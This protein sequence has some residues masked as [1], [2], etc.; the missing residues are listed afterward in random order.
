MNIVLTG[1]LGNISKPLAQILL[2]KGHSPTVISGKADRQKDIEALGTKAAIGSL[3]DAAFLSLAFKGADIVY[4]MEPPFHFTDPNANSETLWQDIAHTYVEAIQKAGVTKVVHLSSI[5]GHTDK[6]V[7]IL[8]WHYHVEQILKR[9]LPAVSIKT[10]RPVGFYGNLLANISILKQLSQGFIGGSLA[11]QYYGVAGLLSGKRGVIMGNY[12]GD[13]VNSYV[14]PNDIAAF[15]AEEMEKLFT[16]R[17][18]R[19]IASEEL[20]G[21]QIAK[22]LGEAI[23]KPYLKHGKISDKILASALKKQG[24]D[25]KLASGIVEMGVSGRTGKLYEDY[26]KHKL[27]LGKPS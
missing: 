7:G 19:Y 8:S 17:M 12:D 1:S 3:F 6:G 27:V 18:V 13:V 4:L 10:M 23:G 11:L 25:V 22:V 2:Q 21:N 14:S 24:L 15:I 16:G 5:G 20:T 9:L 26:N